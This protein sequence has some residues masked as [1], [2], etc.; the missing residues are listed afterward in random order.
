MR[1]Q[2]NLFNKGYI[3]LKAGRISN[4]ALSVLKHIYHYQLSYFT[5]GDC[6]RFRNEVLLGLWK[7]FLENIAA[8]KLQLKPPPPFRSIFELYSIF[9]ASERPH[10]PPRYFPNSHPD[11]QYLITTN[12]S[13]P[14]ESEKYQLVKKKDEY[15]LREYLIS[16]Q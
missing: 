11:L 7:Q 12:F 5:V 16:R 3:L 13:N 15:L 6:H 14:A 8:G 1:F 9:Q 10:E 4:G 2:K